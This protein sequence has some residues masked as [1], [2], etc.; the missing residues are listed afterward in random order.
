VTIRTDDFANQPDFTVY[1]TARW[2]N[3]LTTAFPHMQDVSAVVR[4]A[5]G[6]E[7]LLCGLMTDRVGAW[8][9]I[10]AM[11]FALFGGPVAKEGR[12]EAEDVAAVVQPLRKGAGWFSLNLDPLNR[13]AT[14]AMLGEM[15]STL[16]THVLRLEA[17]PER[18]EKRYTKTL[19]YDIRQAE[20]QQVL[21]R[22]GTGHEDFQRYYELTQLAAQ[23]WGLSST[24]FPAALYRALATLPSDE[25]RLWLAEAEGRAIGGL[26]CI[27]YAPGRSLYWG[28]SMHPDAVRLNP[29]KL[30]LHRA[31]DEAI[32]A[33]CTTMNMGP[34]AGFDGRPL[35]GVRQFKEAFGAEAMT[36]AVGLAMQPWAVRARAVRERLKRLIRRRD[37]E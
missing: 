8:R 37:S 22:R 7:V 33:G 4:L 36:Y 18:M 24:P 25:V 15:G 14:T 2:R 31:I 20:K 6:R 1:H 12:L 16:T 21:A 23:K 5:D 26:L 34:S 35:E 29:T 11:P 27:H 28:S 32:R 10:E 17:E 13:L 3:A 30:L 19:R 9:W